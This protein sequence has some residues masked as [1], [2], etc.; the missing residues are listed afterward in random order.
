MKA[1]DNTC[2]RFCWFRLEERQGIRKSG[3][4]TD[5]YTP[6]CGYSPRHTHHAN[7]RPRGIGSLLTE[8]LLLL[9]IF[10]LPL[11]SHPFRFPFMD[12]VALA[13]SSSPSLTVHE[14][15]YTSSI[16]FL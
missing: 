3:D 1:D 15:V 12:A 14:L 7:Q 16:P 6:P 9:R 11:L 2:C 10:L 4:G 8:H 13:F 5:R